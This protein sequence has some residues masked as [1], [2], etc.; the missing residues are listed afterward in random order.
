MG[1]PCTLVTLYYAA[2]GR[3]L[4]ACG[5]TAAGQASPA[6]A[7]AD[8][9]AMIAGEVARMGCDSATRFCCREEKRATAPAATPRCTF[10][11][12]PCLPCALRCMP[13]YIP[14]A[15]LALSPP[16]WA[17]ILS[18]YG[19]FLPAN[20]YRT[21]HSTCVVPAGMRFAAWRLNAAAA[22]ACG[23]WAGRAWLC[24]GNIRLSA[25]ASFSATYLHAARTRTAAFPRG[26]HMAERRRHPSA[27]LQTC[28]CAYACSFLA[29]LLAPVFIC[30]WCAATAAPC[31]PLCARLLSSGSIFVN[32]LGRDYCGTVSGAC[33]P[34]L[35]PEL[36][37]TAAPQ[38]GGREGGGAGGR[39]RLERRYG[40]L[41]LGAGRIHA[42]CTYLL[43]LL[44]CCYRFTSA[45]HT[46][47]GMRHFLRSNLLCRGGLPYSYSS[48]CRA[49]STLSSL[50]SSAAVAWRRAGAVWLHFDLWRILIS[51]VTRIKQ[52]CLSLRRC[53]GRDGAVCLRS[54]CRALAR[55][56]ARGK[57]RV[58]A[59]LLHLHLSRRGDM[60]S[61]SQDDLALQR[62]RRAAGARYGQVGNRYSRLSM[63]FRRGAARRLFSG[64]QRRLAFRVAGFMY[65]RC[66]WHIRKDNGTKEGSHSLIFPCMV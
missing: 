48:L 13:P 54:N 56:M 24:G 40:H 43:D 45:C 50:A 31:L 61:P 12:P 5:G 19:R 64:C 26:V 2:A 55:A 58:N 60:V 21:C 22:G 20:G 63:A 33:F 52:T 17:F 47:K 38:P 10:R 36:V 28:A 41:S 7:G 42:A 62:G 65:K 49:T 3:E 53:G 32:S 4:Q 6:E 9:C 29:S 57:C 1:R 23:D 15:P 35:A 14:A 27:L 39:R 46:L 11:F 18:D 16:W 44:C 34:W 30:G 66:S 51:L 59:R 8:V 25:N 37:A